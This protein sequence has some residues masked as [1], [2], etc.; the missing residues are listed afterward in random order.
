MIRGRFTGYCCTLRSVK[1]LS[2]SSELN[3]FVGWA[4]STVIVTVCVMELKI[5]ASSP[6]LDCTGS[7][8]MGRVGRT[9]EADPVT[10]D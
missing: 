2:A 7:R 1:P 4:L 6:R 9:T 5:L 8:A 3:E 10:E